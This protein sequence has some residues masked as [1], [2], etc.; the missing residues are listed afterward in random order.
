HPPGYPLYTLLYHLPTKYLPLRTPFYVASLVT[1]LITITWM[2]ILIIN[3]RTQSSA[4]ILLVLGSSLLFW[5]YAV[6]PDV[7]TL[8]MFFIV[9]VFLVFFQPSLLNKWWVIFIVSLSVAH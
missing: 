2:G 4:L 8:H 9:L 1:V 7:F 6:L 3:N 5:R